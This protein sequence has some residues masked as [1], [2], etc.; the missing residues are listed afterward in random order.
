MN[1]NI[2][3]FAYKQN[4]AAAGHH[5]GRHTRARRGEV[6]GV[7]REGHL[8]VQP[9]GQAGGRHP[10]HGQK[11]TQTFINDDKVHNLTICKQMVICV[12]R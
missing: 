2:P 6:P 3:I 9:W 1:T 7:G 11:K 5:Q 4:H 12:T 10:S 8:G